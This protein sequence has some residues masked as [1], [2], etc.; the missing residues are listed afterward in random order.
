VKFSARIFDFLCTGDG[1]E[2]RVDIKRHFDDR[3]LLSSSMVVLTS[4]VD[5]LS[6]VWSVIR[7]GFRL[8][9]NH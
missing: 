5:K 2:D 4:P 3:W 1:E 7:P 8:N 9:K 6:S